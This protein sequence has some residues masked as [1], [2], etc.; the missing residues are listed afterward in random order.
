MRSEYDG[1]RLNAKRSEGA[2]GER[3]RNRI[4]NCFINVYLSIFYKQNNISAF[5]NIFIEQFE[6][7]ENTY[8]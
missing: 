4:S 3:G 7:T 6:F 8:F 2:F 5:K 1:C